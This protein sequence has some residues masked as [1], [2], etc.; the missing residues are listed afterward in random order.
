MPAVERPGFMKRKSYRDDEYLEAILILKRSRGEVRV[1]D[2]AS[3]LGVK[4]PSVVEY[5]ERLSEKGLIVYQKGKG[6]IDFTDR[7]LQRAMEVYQRHQVL[8]RLLKLLGVRDEVAEEDA[9]SIEHVIS[10]ETFTAFERLARCLE[11][12]PN[13][14]LACLQQG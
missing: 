2:L 1:K 6:V 5:L 4:P 13:E 8:K 12:S 9:C 10:D 7:G 11:E 14:V 3:L